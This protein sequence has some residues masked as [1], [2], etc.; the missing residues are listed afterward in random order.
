M[1]LGF[2]R[3][4]ALILSPRYLPTK[5][6]NIA[7][8]LRLRGDA[9]AL[10]VWNR[11]FAAEDYL[12]LNPD[13]ARRGV[14]PGAHFL[15]CSNR[16]LRDPSSRFD[17][18][19]YLERY[20]AVAQSGVNPLL[21][22]ALFGKREGR[23]MS[24]RSTLR[25]PDPLPQ[26]PPAQLVNAGAPV[27]SPPTLFVNNSWRRDFPLVSV[28]I[29][30]F[31]N[32]RFLEEGIRSILNQTFQDF[33]L[34]V[35]EGGS[36]EANTVETV[37]RL[38]SLGFPKTRFY[39]RPERHH[40]GDNKN[41]GT[42]LARGRYICCLD[43][44]DML[45]QVYLEVAVFLAEVFGYELIYPSLRAFGKPGTRWAWGDA[46]LR[47]LVVD[48]SF[49]EILRQNLVP[50]SAVFTRDSWARVGGYRDFGVFEE[51][52]QEDWDFWMRLVGHGF[53][54]ISIRD[55]LH[56]YRVLDSGMTASYK[57]DLQRQRER[58]ALANA[59]LVDNWRQ[60]EKIQPTILNPY[61]NLGPVDD[62]RPGVLFGLPA[63]AD[64]EAREGFRS[65]GESIVA[66]GERL[67]V[68]TSVT[69][70]EAKS[71]DAWQVPDPDGCFDDITSHV[72]RL[73]WL[74]HNE[75]HWREFLR[76]LIRRYRVQTVI[77]AGCELL[78]RM[79]PDL[80]REFPEIAVVDQ[81]SAQQTK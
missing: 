78:E 41:F 60:A 69:A 3:S 15:L 31:N 64:Q 47:W 80:H 56:F 27:E 51:Y 13:V 59:A 46:N 73:S 14:A 17:T 52:V 62:G 2:L 37:R 55:L 21:H 76:Y 9:E 57:P 54:G 8:W 10:E 5:A 29:P 63:L 61:A 43:Q 26:E 66:R 45:G 1:L 25:D 23:T 30:V 58:L 49:P 28:V 67:V 70:A 79:L 74:F 53:R 4:A 33:E 50:N 24:D 18:R 20:P 68:V 65:Q 34:I 75:E 81:L 48:P 22:Y 6:R 7:L 71:E 38:E 39:Y 42:A 72:Y 77:F 19:Y 36:T 40:V 16:E 32:A 35:V 44:D 11:Y 12:S